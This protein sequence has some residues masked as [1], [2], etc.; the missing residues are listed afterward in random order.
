M[1]RFRSNYECATLR[2]SPVIGF[3]LSAANTAMTQPRFVPN[4]QVFIQ[5]RQ[6]ALIITNYNYD[7]YM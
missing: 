3:G 5:R 7:C 4:H 6:H 1:V 2:H